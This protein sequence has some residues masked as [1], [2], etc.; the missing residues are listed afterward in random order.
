MSDDL[1]TEINLDLIQQLCLEAGRIM[2]DVSAEMAI[3]LPRSLEAVNTRVDQLCTAAEQIT[4]LANAAR[5][6][7]RYRAS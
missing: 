4:T 1:P 7:I 2:E 5:S 3:A 6:L